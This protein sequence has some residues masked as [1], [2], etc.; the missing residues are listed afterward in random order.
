ML[1]EATGR[2]Q[3]GRARARTALASSTTFGYGLGRMFDQAREVQDS[4]V[5]YRSFHNRAEAMAW[6]GEE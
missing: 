4:P 3:G 6:L 1:A 5:A 2:F